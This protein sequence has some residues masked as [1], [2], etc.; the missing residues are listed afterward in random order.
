MTPFIH[1]SGGAV[2]LGNMRLD[3]GSQVH[4]LEVTGDEFKAA[5]RAGDEAAMKVAA[6]KA[7]ALLCARRFARRWAQTE[8]VR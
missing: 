7:T 3:E 1:H 4:L 5:L 2:M 8:A 6:T